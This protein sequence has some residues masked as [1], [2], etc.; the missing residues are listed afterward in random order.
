M[1]TEHRTAR[2]YDHCMRD[3]A[4]VHCSDTDLIRTVMDNLST[5]TPGALYEACPAPTAHRILRHLA[6]HNAPKHAGWLDMMEIEI[7]ELGGQC[8]DRRIGERDVLISEVL[9]ARRRRFV[10]RSRGAEPA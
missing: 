2:N 3:L 1:V 10:Q 7:A 8:L 9:S 4:D 6:F 5:H